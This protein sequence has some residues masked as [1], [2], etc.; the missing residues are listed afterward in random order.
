MSCFSC[1]LQA[2]VALKKWY[3]L[4]VETLLPHCRVPKPSPFD[5]T[6]LLYQMNSAGS[7]LNSSWCLNISPVKYLYINCKQ[8]PRFKVWLCTVNSQ[9]TSQNTKLFE[10]YFS[11]PLD[12]FEGLSYDLF[13][14]FMTTKMQKIPFSTLC[15]LPKSYCKAVN[16]RQW[17]QPF[18]GKV[19]VRKLS[20]PCIQFFSFTPGACSFCLL[21]TICSTST[22]SEGFVIVVPCDMFVLHL[23]NQAQVASIILNLFHW[24]FLG[25][26]G[27]EGSEG[28]HFGF[29]KWMKNVSSALF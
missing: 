23:W 15:S 5:L 25:S 29:R 12:I 22:H 24:F 17:F 2:P 28:I 7:C 27:K 8:R 14:Q 9:D 4:P 6:W 13:E 21:I 1:M 11:R 26:L 16:H 18:H 3:V 20:M 19:S 10:V